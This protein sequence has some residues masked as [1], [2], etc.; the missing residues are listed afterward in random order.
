M[1]GTVVKARDYINEEETALN[2]V[3]HVSKWV[4][5]CKFQIKYAAMPVGRVRYMRTLSE[6]HGHLHKGDSIAPPLGR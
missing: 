6:N 2:I 3:E 1:R 4:H 5:T